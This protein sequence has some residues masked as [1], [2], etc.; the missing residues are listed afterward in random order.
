M[1]VEAAP[2]AVTARKVLVA[3]DSPITQDLLKLLLKQR[4]HQVDT[5]TDGWQAFEALRKNQYDVALLDFHLPNMNGAEV[6]AGIRREANGRRLPQLVAMTAD[7]EGL[8]A[9]PNSEDLDHIIPKPLD[10]YEVGKL[11]EEQADIG[12]RRAANPRRPGKS[13]QAGRR[14]R[15]SH[16]FSRGKD[17]NSWR[18]RTT[19]ANRVSRPG[20]CRRAWG[21]RAS[22]PS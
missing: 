10:I 5:V 7:I 1:T 17:T 4:G 2:E 9:C 16:R 14:R 13:K 22:T 6:A 3:E 21:T 11:I 20:A 15:L 19:S 18:G 12:A 8:L